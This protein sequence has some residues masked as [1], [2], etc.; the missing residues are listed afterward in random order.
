VGGRVGDLAPGGLPDVAADVQAQNPVSE[1]DLAKVQHVQSLFRIGVLADPESGIR[2]V[3]PDAQDDPT[4]QR[5]SEVLT[6]ELAS[7]AS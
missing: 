6:V 2:D 7:E 5:Q 1:V 3:G 4:F